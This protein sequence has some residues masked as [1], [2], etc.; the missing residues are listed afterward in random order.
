[1]NIDKLTIDINHDIQELLYKYKA[2][3]YIHN[4]NI[5]LT[6]DILC[7]SE[8]FDNTIDICLGKEVS[9]KRLSAGFNT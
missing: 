4:G 6:S 5:F 2:S 3:L 8:L 1:M 7:T 9:Y